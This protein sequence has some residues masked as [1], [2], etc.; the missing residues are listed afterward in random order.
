MTAPVDLAQLG[1][2][3]S[4]VVVRDV[5]PAEVWLSDGNVYRTARAVVTR[6]RVYVFQG[7]GR[8]RLLRFVAEYDPERSAI[9]RYNASPRENTTLALQ[10]V[11]EPALGLASLT[12]RRQ[13]GCGCGSPLRGWS[14]WNPYRVASS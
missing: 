6:E 5:F 13:R 12:I 7:Q 11:Q 4:P 9:P 2:E 14:P 1:A 3:A 8:D 10:G